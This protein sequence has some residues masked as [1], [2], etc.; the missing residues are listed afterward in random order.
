MLLSEKAVLRRVSHVSYEEWNDSINCTCINVCFFKKIA[1]YSED[2]FK[3]LSYYP[4]ASR[5]ESHLF[6]LFNFTREP[7]A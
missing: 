1:S 3:F 7:H 6:V 4:Q 5:K 2:I